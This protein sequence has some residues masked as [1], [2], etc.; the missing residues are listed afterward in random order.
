M[1]FSKFPLCLLAG[2]GFLV[3]HW[4]CLMVV[5]CPPIDICILSIFPIQI[6]MNTVFVAS[7]L[8]FFIVGLG[9]LLAIQHMPQLRD[10]YEPTAE[11]KKPLEV[12]ERMLQPIEPVALEAARLPNPRYKFEGSIANSA[13][14]LAPGAQPMH[15]VVI[16]SDWYRSAYLPTEFDGPMWPNGDIGPD[17]LYPGSDLKRPLRSQNLGA[18]QRQV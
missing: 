10:I 15:E 7:L 17:Y 3:V 8:V 1:L 16:P 11:A 6:D 4:K 14:G 18:A 12:S 2:L 13:S 5:W 9:L